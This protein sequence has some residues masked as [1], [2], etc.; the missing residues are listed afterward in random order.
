MPAVGIDP[1]RVL[2]LARDVL[3]TEA[4]AIVALEGRLGSSFLA[5]ARALYDCKGRVVV[6]GI[7]KS[8]HIARKARGHARIDG[9]SRLFRARGPKPVTAT[10]A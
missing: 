2:T 7:G 1:E 10:W 4:A 3:A 5:A 9:D 6:T 8:G